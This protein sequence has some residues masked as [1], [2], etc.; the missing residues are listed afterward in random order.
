MSNIF[1]VE[2]CTHDIMTSDHSPVFATFQIGG[3]KQHAS[4]S[5]GCTS[6]SSSDAYIILQ[7]CSAKV[8]LN[9]RSVTYKAVCF[10]TYQFERFK[11]LFFNNL[12]IIIVFHCPYVCMTAV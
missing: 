1:G 4:S 5:V 2:G 9:K 10:V 8:N 7:K 11:F 3:V 12:F 6:L